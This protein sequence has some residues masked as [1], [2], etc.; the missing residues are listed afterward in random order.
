MVRKLANWYED[1]QLAEG[2]LEDTLEELS[3]FVVVMAG[4]AIN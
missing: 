3:I 4:Q 1:Q 2:L